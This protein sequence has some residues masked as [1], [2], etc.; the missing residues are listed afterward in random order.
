MTR[1]NVSSF[2]LEVAAGLSRILRERR[3][4]TDPLPTSPAAR[5]SRHAPVQAAPPAIEPADGQDPELELVKLDSWEVFLAWSLE[6][7]RSRAGF[8]VDSQGFV[9]ASRGNVPKDGFDGIG[10]ELCYAMDQLDKISPESGHLRVLELGFTGSRITGIKIAG[11][12]LGPLVIGFLGSRPL[13]DELRDSIVRQLDLN[14]ER[15]S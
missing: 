15:M 13:T 9:I 10:A 14:R 11:E 2:D 1:P 4:T 3:P 12:A 5:F 8:V 7:T 6:L